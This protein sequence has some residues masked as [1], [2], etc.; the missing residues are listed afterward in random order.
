MEQGWSNIE[1]GGPT[2][3][4]TSAVRCVRGRDTPDV[5]SRRHTEKKVKCKLKCS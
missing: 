4:T 1:H 3:R 5:M 2:A